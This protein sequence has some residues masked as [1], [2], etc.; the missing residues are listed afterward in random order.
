MKMKC[1]KAPVSIV[2]LL[3]TDTQLAVW[4]DP[5]KPFSAGLGPGPHPAVTPHQE[6][7][8]DHDCI[9]LSILLHVQSECSINTVC[10]FPRSFTRKLL[11]P[12]QRKKRRCWTVLPG[13]HCC[14]GVRTGCSLPELPQ[15][16]SHLLTKAPP[17]NL[18]VVC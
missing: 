5:K 6:W 15:V 8:T 4:Q 16:Q 10:G 11:L 1:K 17:W 2:A 18:C 9:Q 13:G 7:L 14:P 12:P 3:R